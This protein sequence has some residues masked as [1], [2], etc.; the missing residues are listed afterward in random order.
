[1]IAAAMKP[2]QRMR[3]ELIL[4]HFYKIH[5][6]LCYVG[7]WWSQIYLHISPLHRQS[8]QMLSMK[9]KNL[10]V[11]SHI[12]KCAIL[13]HCQYRCCWLVSFKS[14]LNLIFWKCILDKFVY[15]CK[16]RHSVVK[17]DM[18]CPSEAV[19]IANATSFFNHDNPPRPSKQILR[20]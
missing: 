13:A 4:L 19:P 1:M 6:P 14:L 5:M 2:Q 11:F 15:T 17:G 16:F 9:V 3:F 18:R 7:C 8:P 12:V 20:G 10:F